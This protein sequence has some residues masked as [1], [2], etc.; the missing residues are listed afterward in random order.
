MLPLLTVLGVYYTG[1][2]LNPA[3]SLGPEV[4]LR[5]FYHDHWVRSRI[6]CETA[7]C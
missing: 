1:G 4:V 2:S 6:S 7:P 5:K 3:R